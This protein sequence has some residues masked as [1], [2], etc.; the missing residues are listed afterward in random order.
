MTTHQSFT[1]HFRAQVARTPDQEALILLTERDGQL[2]PETV[3]YAELDR[4]ARILAAR[5]QRH[6]PAGE[7]ILIAHSSR[8]LFTIS[9]LAC[10][11]AGAVAVPIASPG[12]R[13]HHDERVAGIIKDAAVSCVLTATDEAAE[14]SQLLARTGYGHVTC[15]LADTPLTAADADDWQAPETTSDTTVFLQYTSGSTRD[16]RG[17][18][19]THR[20]LLA[21]QR[22]ISEAFGTRPG[23]RLAGWLPFHHDMGLVGLLLH[24][25][26]LGGTA[27]LL[28]PIAF[29]KKPL[30][31]LET[32]S[33]Y[34][35]T[36]SGAPDFAYEL[37]VRRINDAQIARLDL[38][39]WEIAL[40]GGESVSS[41][42]VRTFNERFASA[43]LRPEAMIP[44]YGL[45]EATLL[46]SGSASAPAVGHPLRDTVLPGFD[47][48]RGGPRP[49][50]DV[51]HCGPGASADL[52]IVDPDTCEE[53]ADGQ[54]GEIWVSST[55]IGPGYFSRP[56][57]TAA[58]FGGRIVDGPRG[59]Y[60]RTGDLGTVQDGLLYVTGRIK[61]MIV[62]AGRNLYPQDLERTVQQVSPLF[63]AS[64]AFSVPSRPARERIV[65]V[66]ELR[67][68][69]RYDI[70]LEQLAAAIA[71]RLSEEHEVRTGAILFVRQGTVRRT[72]SGKVER[73][74]MRRLFLR[75]ELTALHERIE[76][77]VQQLVTAGSAR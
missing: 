31:W 34:D 15:I 23:S 13:G 12:G 48:R 61:D 69:S 62:V 64:T 71:Q 17:V 70:D 19:V 27:V 22:A 41:D 14:V 59:G 35:V 58:V 18:V 6:A 26:Y 65:V 38:S 49:R 66:Q 10:L 54:V 5:V 32:I 46:V 1:E 40:N 16:P 3:S 60:L 72:T 73:A 37:C 30:H 67:T 44:C 42:T 28:S 20:S 36:V 43:G 52:R 25:L 74:M 39:R 33:K 7:R 47:E 63:G 76:P 56:A 57:E 50:R 55:S 2:W 9:F 77:E 24:S 11:Y 53:L 29:V 68:R 8:R 75:G 4:S 21:N 45:A 51:V